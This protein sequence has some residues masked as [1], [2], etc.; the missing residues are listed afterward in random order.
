MRNL[1]RMFPAE[2]APRD[3]ELTPKH[4]SD[5]GRANEVFAARPMNFNPVEAAAA[6]GALGSRLNEPPPDDAPKRR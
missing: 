6:P 2:E 1:K 3:V 4:L 5:P